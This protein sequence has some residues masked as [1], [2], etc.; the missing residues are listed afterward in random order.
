MRQIVKKLGVVAVLI[1][2]G[3]WAGTALGFSSYGS[4][5]NNFCAPATPYT[6][7][8]TLCHA[9]SSKAAPTPAKDAYLAGD[10]GYF[11]PA[12]T[13]VVADAGPAQTVAEGA[14]VVLNGSNSS[15]PISTYQWTQTS[16]P[17]VTLSG[18]ATAQARFTAPAVGTTGASL[19]FQLT[20]RDAAGAASS[21]SVTVNVT[22]VNQPPVASA[23]PNQTVARGTPVTLDGSNSSDP[24]GTIAAYLW[25]QTAGT[26][27]TLSSTN[28]ARPTFAAPAVGAGGAALTFRLT[29]TD[30][31]GLTAS[32]TTTVNVTAA[33]QPPV[34]DAGP[35]QT[36]S[37]GAT[38]TLNGS[39]SSDPDGTIASYLWTQTSGTSVTLSSTTVARPTFTAPASGSLSF[40][41][42]LTDNQ[43]LSANATTTVTVSVPSANQPPVAQA[44]ADQ[45]VSAGATVTLNGTGSSDPD[46]AI[47]SYLWEHVGGAAV[48]LS[49]PSTA[50]PM[51]QAP[52]SGALTFNLTVTDNGGL[53]ATDTTVVNVVA[54]ELPPVASATAPAEA[55]AGGQ[56]VLD[57]SASSG[58]ASYQWKQR[59]GPPVTLSNP[60]D[61]KP[62]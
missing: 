30:S 40:Q 44:G 7:D 4:T 53:I 16:G 46:G 12:T 55:V 42:K 45:N 19:G 13:P 47:V 10:L 11:C 5:V 48:T 18:V 31:G 27:V 38:V 17:A 49:N 33:N 3:G 41:L 28:V 34:A 14:A 62:T 57:G 50:S 51:F 9:A 56:V 25:T 54:G 6:G 52:S 29:V 8:C 22:N 60:A 35:S 43:G 20:V 23:G 37:P 58:A 36:V 1:T 59:S 32:A 2:A 24:D 39:N 21:A 15:G 61:P 26:T